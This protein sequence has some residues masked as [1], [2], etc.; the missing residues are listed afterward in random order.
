MMD[1]KI[2]KS[3]NAL[4]FKRETDIWCQCVEKRPKG[5]ITK[6]GI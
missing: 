2:G 4:V 3:V 6:D 5:R 1:K